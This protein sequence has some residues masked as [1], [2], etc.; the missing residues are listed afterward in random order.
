MHW[1]LRRP[2]SGFPN[3]FPILYE[4]EI[5]TN[6]RLNIFDSKINP[7]IVAVSD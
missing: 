1:K 5:E 7:R 3:D 4:H 6:K 2:H